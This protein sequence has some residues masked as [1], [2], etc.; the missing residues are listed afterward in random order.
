MKDTT[1]KNIYIQPDIDDR[2][3]LR[4]SLKK[5][6]SQNRKRYCKPITNARSFLK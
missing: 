5:V 2:I 1:D 6:Y 4:E 3:K